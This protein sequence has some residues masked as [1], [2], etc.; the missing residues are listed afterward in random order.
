MQRELWARGRKLGTLLPRGTAILWLGLMLLI[1][2]SLPLFALFASMMSERA[3]LRA[4]L[5]AAQHVSAEPASLETLLAL[6]AAAV[7]GTSAELAIARALHPLPWPVV[8]ERVLPSPA[9]GVRLVGL[10]QRGQEIQ[11]R[12]IASAEASLAAYEAHLRASPLFRSV[13]VQRSLTAPGALT[14][15][16]TL[17]LAEYAT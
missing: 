9:A 12:A 13:S 15:T 4:A 8:L 10:S 5:V 6:R 1:L 7:E 16:A 3:R 2:L 17:T 11:L 14:F